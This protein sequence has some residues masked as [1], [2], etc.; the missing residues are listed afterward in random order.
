M[1]AVT[2]LTGIY[3]GQDKIFWTNHISE[4]RGIL[5]ELTSEAEVGEQVRS[6]HESHRGGLNVADRPTPSWQG[7]QTRGLSAAPI[8]S[9][10]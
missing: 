7:S 5:K 9:L 8:R 10:R 4:V 1:V 2:S 3:R 6:G